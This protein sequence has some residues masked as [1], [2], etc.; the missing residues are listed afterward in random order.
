MADLYNTLSALCRERGIT[1]YKMCKD[2]GIQPS[3]M[4]DLKMGRRKGVNAETADKIASYFGVSVGY[5]LGTEQ[6]EK[7]SVD[8]DEE[9]DKLLEMYRTRP[10]CRML[11]SL[12]AGATVEDV[13]KAA[14]IIEAIRKVEE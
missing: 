3:I 11:F 13:K 2:V 4:T 5:L 10:E 7:P 8:N 6:K 1:G 14:A 9:L 12:A